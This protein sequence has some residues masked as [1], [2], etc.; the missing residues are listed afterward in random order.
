[1]NL[2]PGPPLDDSAASHDARVR[3]L[4]RAF[5]GSLVLSDGRTLLPVPPPGRRPARPLYAPYPAFPVGGRPARRIT[6]AE[7]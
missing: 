2:R 4:L 3:W 5:P 6:R 1:M 7:R